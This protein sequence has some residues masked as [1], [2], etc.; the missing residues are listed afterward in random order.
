MKPQ[1]LVINV[2]VDGVLYDFVGTF[3][4]YVEDRHY[5]GAKTLPTPVQWATWDAW[6]ITQKDFYRYLHEGARYNVLFRVGPALE[7]AVEAMQTL[8]KEGHYLRIVT[9]KMLREP[10][11][12]LAAQ[13]SVLDWLDRQQIPYHGI[14]FVGSSSEKALLRADV[15]VDD[16]PNAAWAIPGKRNILFT[17]PWNDLVPTGRLTRANNWAEVL[18]IIRTDAEVLAGLMDVEGVPI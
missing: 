17:Q 16:K 1:R 6:G 9:S 2:D 14:S 10:T 3:K 8:E 18:D 7:G 12:R 11:A 15:I 4:R 13:L 5:D